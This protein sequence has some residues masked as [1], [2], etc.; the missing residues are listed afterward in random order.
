MSKPFIEVK[1]I[2]QLCKLIGLPNS[3]AARI[4]VRRDLVVAIYNR[5]KEKELTHVEAAKLA[6]VGR[7][8]ITAIVNGN[9]G[10]ISTDKLIEIADRIGLSIHINVA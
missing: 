1:N 4:E 9:I 10:K 2:R 8:V 7:T 5:I 3:H 6:G